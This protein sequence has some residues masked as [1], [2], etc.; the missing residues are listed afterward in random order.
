MAPM[1]IYADKDS[2]YYI[3]NKRMDMNRLRYRNEE[4]NLQKPFIGQLGDVNG[5]GEMVWL[6]SCTWCNI[7]LNG[8]FPMS[9]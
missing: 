1:C 7:Y 3:C 5:D 9:K 4:I 8:K 2:T 6:T